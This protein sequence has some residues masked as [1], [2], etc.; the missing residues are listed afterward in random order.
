MTEE[1]IKLI[2]KWI[3]ILY[4]KAGQFTLFDEFYKETQLR[5]NQG[6][7]TPFE[8][9]Q[10]T[11]L[12]TQKGL[13][14]AQ[15]NYT[16]TKFTQLAYDIYFA[17]GWNEYQNKISYNQ[18]RQKEIDGLTI[19][20]LKIDLKNAKRQ[21]KFFYPLTFI[22]FLSAGVTIASLIINT[23]NNNSIKNLEIRTDTIDISVS[24]IKTVL[25]L[26]RPDTSKG[27]SVPFQ[28]SINNK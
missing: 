8:L 4:S 23:R 13:I 26:V 27:D 14:E 28:H 22:A 12:F 7:E 25:E 24:K 15:N 20:K 19:D 3:K 1:E 11:K 5:Y 2:D 9:S 21:G 6:G 16:A 18:Q 17:G 10:I